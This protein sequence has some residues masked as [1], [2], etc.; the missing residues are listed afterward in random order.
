MT[1]ILCLI[2]RRTIIGSFFYSWISDI[3]NDFSMF[4]FIANTYPIEWM[5]TACPTHAQTLCGR[6]VHATKH[7]NCH[8]NNWANFRVNNT[9]IVQ[10]HPLKCSM[11]LFQYECNTIERNT[12]DDETKTNKYCFQKWPIFKK[13]LLIN[14]FSS[15]DWA[16]FV[17]IL[18]IFLCK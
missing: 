7:I 17:S 9:T 4:A 14:Y 13:W 2:W 6:A 10:L 5:C 3:R 18:Y 15:N 11:N 12:E 1:M 16:D 8:T